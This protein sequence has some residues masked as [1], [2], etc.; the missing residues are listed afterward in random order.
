MEEKNIIK[1]KF[2][3][4]NIFVIV[5]LVLS[6]VSFLISIWI[7]YD[8]CAYRD[9]W[10]RPV[11]YSRFIIRPGEVGPGTITIF[12][13]LAILLFFVAIFFVIKM[14]RCKLNVSNK[15]VS[16]KASFG[17]I[18][19][20]PIDEIISV[21]T[22]FPKGITVATSSRTIKFWLLVNREG[23]YQAISDLIKQKQGNFAD[24][25]NNSIDDLRK[26][27]D[28]LDNGTITQEEFDAKK[29]QLLG[30]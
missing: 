24:N 19:N 3:K 22:C 12:S 23:V 27:K 2:S 26:L 30:L 5:P 9:Y 10:G 29:K 21:G 11:P 28:L 17:R 15:K 16:G 7:Y 1:G 4:S 6:A 8:D 18:I 13:Y 25:Q 20:L 14:N